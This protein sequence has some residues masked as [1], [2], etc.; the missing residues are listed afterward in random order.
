MYLL[1]ENASNALAPLEGKLEKKNPC[2][3]RA[4][5]NCIASSYQKKSGANGISACLKVE[6]RKRGEEGSF[7][8]GSK[9]SSLPRAAAGLQDF[10]LP[11]CIG[12]LPRCPSLF[13]LLPSDPYIFGSPLKGLVFFARETAKKSFF[14]FF[15]FLLFRP[16]VPSPIST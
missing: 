15:L 3:F 2:S 5:H 10:F 11:S 13:F 14:S 16:S 8:F 9:K 4:K 1:P 7:F 6:G 12:R